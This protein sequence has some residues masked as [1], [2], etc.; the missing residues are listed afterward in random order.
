MDK[1]RK[2]KTLIIKGLKIELKDDKKLENQWKI[3]QLSSNRNKTKNK[4][5]R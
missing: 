4:T 2:Q 3:F 1:E 5:S